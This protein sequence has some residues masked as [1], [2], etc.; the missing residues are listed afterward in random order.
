MTASQPLGDRASTSM[1]TLTAIT[2]S[3]VQGGT[4]RT[5]QHPPHVVTLSLW[6]EAQSVGGEQDTDP[7]AS[8][9]PVRRG[10]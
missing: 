4:P 9:E 2:Q 5:F 7:P 1:A 6:G 3:M 8:V 10:A